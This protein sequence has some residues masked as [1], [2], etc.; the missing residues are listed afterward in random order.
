MS[1][2]VAAAQ[3]LVV[4]QTLYE[5]PTSFLQKT[6]LQPYVRYDSVALFFL[7]TL[8]HRQGTI[9]GSR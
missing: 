4:Y 8:T 1:E 3:V 6:G 7:Y 2:D 9:K 5:D